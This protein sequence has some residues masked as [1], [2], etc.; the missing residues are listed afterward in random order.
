MNSGVN[1]YTIMA[2]VSSSVAGRTD[3]GIF[4]GG[5]SVDGNMPASKPG[6]VAFSLHMSPSQQQCNSG[7]FDV[8]IR[9][10]NA[11]SLHAT[12]SKKQPLTLAVAVF[13]VLSYCQST[14]Q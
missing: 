12:V 1:V 11:R 14:K 4:S 10:A 5:G 9:H 3:A 2:V 13:V 7:S 8:C 6:N